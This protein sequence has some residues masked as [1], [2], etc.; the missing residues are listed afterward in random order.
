MSGNILIQV[1]IM[2]FYDH[3][4]GMTNMS[5]D[6]KLNKEK[7]YTLRM[8]SC[9]SQ[10]ELAAASGLSV[11]TIQRVEKTGSASLETAKALASVFAVSPMALQGSKGVENIAFSFICKY[12]WLMAFAAASLFFGLWVID[13]LIPT[14]KGADFNQQYELH[15]NFRYLDFGG[16]AFV[17]GFALLGLN[18]FYDYMSQKRL[19]NGT[20]N[21]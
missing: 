15:G 12:A 8:A 3:F 17:V 20:D 5:Q 13:I 2:T 21:K 9:W 16:I 18:I 19:L 1:A 6:V 4:K 10:D 14:L 11:R 7:I